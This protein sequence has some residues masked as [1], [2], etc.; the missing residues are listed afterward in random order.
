MP[1]LNLIA[2]LPIFEV[3]SLDAGGSGRYGKT[4]K[5]R[6]PDANKLVRLECP[7]AEFWPSQSIAKIFN[8]KY[9]I[10]TLLTLI[11]EHVCQNNFGANT[12]HDVSHRKLSGLLRALAVAAPENSEW[13]EKRANA[14]ARH[15]AANSMPYPPPVALDW[16]YVDVAEGDPADTKILVPP[17]TSAPGEQ[18]P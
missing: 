18:L 4:V 3:G 8:R 5:L 15:H 10:S 1:P 9:V 11:S 16:L 13:L 17:M 14:Y 12:I 6:S 2:H 7:D